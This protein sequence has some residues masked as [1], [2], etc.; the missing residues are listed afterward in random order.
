M[1]TTLSALLFFAGAALSLTSSWVVVS[2]IERVGSRL[3]A[4]EALLGV[5]SAL[6]ANAP[7]VT[8]SV[9]ALLEHRGALGTGVVI[10]SNVFNLA[11]LLGLGSIVGGVIALHRRVVVFQGAIAMWVAAVCLV[12]VADLVPAVV[13]LLLALAALVP[14]GAIV[15]LDR[16]RWWRRPSPSDLR[17]WL[18]R[19]IAE[20]ELELSAS[21]H[22]ARGRARDVVVGAGALVVVVVASVAMERGASQLGVRLAVP[23][24]IVGGLVL[25]AVTSLPNAVAAV[26]WAKRG[27]G[28]ALLST[29]LNSNALN[30]AAGFLVPVV[31]IGHV[32]ASSQELL[33]AGWYVGLTAVVLGAAYAQRGL[34]RAVGW[35][36]VAA[37]LVFVAVLAVLS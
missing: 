8:S 1:T 25:A 27:R 9:S 19:A 23:G 2:R 16:S 30:V 14:Y 6:A 32:R 26:Y 24:I 37:Y 31:L 18:A 21:I 20:E 5:V 29:G 11:A 10:G 7:E 13:G 36:I 22:P 35:G 34:R 4:S 15:A 12:T 3:G 17:R 28:V 33:V